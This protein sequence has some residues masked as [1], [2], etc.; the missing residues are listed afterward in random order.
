[1]EKPQRIIGYSE[2]GRPMVM[3]AMGYPMEYIPE[4]T[5]APTGNAPA[6]DSV[7]NPAAR[8][9]FSPSSVDPREIARQAAWQARMLPGPEI[10]PLDRLGPVI[11]MLLGASTAIL[12]IRLMLAIAALITH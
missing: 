8:F 12:C 11:M 7:P 4:P 9:L 2:S 3:S 1:M 5:V 10:T 6:S